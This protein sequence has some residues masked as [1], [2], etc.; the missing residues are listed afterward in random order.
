MLASYEDIK[1]LKDVTKTDLSKAKQFYDVKKMKAIGVLHCKGRAK[2]K[3]T[4]LYH[5][6]QKVDQLS[7]GVNDK[8]IDKYLAYLFEVATEVV[9][10]EMREDGEHANEIRQLTNAKIERAKKKYPELIE[11]FNDLVFEYEAKMQK[12]DWIDTV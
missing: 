9:F 5:T 1:K 11:E 3:I 10:I 4:A 6:Y 2:E 12:N 7:I 8:D